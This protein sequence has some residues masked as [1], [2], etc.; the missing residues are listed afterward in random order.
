M[1]VGKDT[2]L[3]DCDMTKELIQFLVI[4]D[5]EL[6]VAGDDTGLLVVTRGVT[7]QFKD[8]SSKVF[9][10]SGK[11]DGGTWEASIIWS[12]AIWTEKHTGTNTLGIVAFPQ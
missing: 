10:H 8:F 1:D 9:E 6:E 5:G 4:A 12:L 2:A 11:I 7:G 3:C